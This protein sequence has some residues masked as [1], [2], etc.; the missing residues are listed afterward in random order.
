MYK[1]LTGG[2]KGYYYLWP[3]YIKLKEYADMEER[4]I[5]EYELNLSSNE[6]YRMLLHIMEL[7]DIYSNYFFID[8]NCSFNLFPLLEVAKPSLTLL[9]DYW[10]GNKYWVIPSDTVRIVYDQKLVTSINYRP[11]LKTILNNY[12]F[13][14]PD[15]LLDLAYALATKQNIDGELAR[16]ENLKIE[17]QTDVLDAASKLVQ[18]NYSKQKMS[19]YEFQDAIRRILKKKEDFNSVIREART[20]IPNPP[21]E[22]HASSRISLGGGYKFDSP[23]SEIG[24]RPA[25]HDFTDPMDGYSL[26]NRL[27]FMDT[28]LRYYGKSAQLKL[29]NLNLVDFLFLQNRTYFSKPLSW[30]LGIGFE[31]YDRFDENDPLVF[32][33][34]FG[35]GLSWFNNSS[36]LFYG[37]VNIDFFGG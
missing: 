8:E 21:H 18:Y 33:L 4:D 7:N 27:N 9:S 25:Y 10:G 3:Y 35:S 32:H 12:S 34:A 5:W 13:K 2:Y 15:Q 16:V 24:W 31:Q 11:S 6:V 14:I 22:G 29:H 19:Q 20:E 36:G 23:Y 17:R 1:G 37:L 26:G 30:K 28:V